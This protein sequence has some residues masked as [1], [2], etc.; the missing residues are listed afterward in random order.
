VL[1]LKEGRNPFSDGREGRIETEKRG[2]REEREKDLT[3]MT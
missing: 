1:L 2:N 3:K